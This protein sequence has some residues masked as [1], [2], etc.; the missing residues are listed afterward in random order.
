MKTKGISFW[1][2]HLEQFVLGLAV[3]TFLALVAMQFIGNPNAVQVA[4]KE[5]GPGDIDRMLEDEATQ[6][7]AL[8]APGGPDDPP[9]PITLLSPKFE[10]LRTASVNPA[11]TLFAPQVRLHPMPGDFAPST[12]KPF[13]VASIPAPYDLAAGQYIDSLIE[14]DVAG[15]EGLMKRFP[16]PPFDVMWTTV[17]ARFN[18]AE[19]LRQYRTPGASGEI[20]LPPT[21]HNDHVDVL[22]VKLERREYVDGNWTTPVVIDLL[23][24]QYSVREHISGAVTKTTGDAILAEL[25]DP[26]NRLRIIQ[27][28]FFET[29]NVVWQAPLPE[30]E[31]VAVAEGNAQAQAD[32]AQQEIIELNSALARKKAARDQKAKRITDLRC[33]PEEAAPPKA[34]PKAP[35]G[36]APPGLAAPGADDAPSVGGGRG[37][38]GPAAADNTDKA[39]CSSLRKAVKKLE[40]DIKRIEE[41]LAQL[42]PDAA[43]KVDDEVEAPQAQVPTD[44]IDIWAHDMTVEPGKTYSY[45]LYVEVFNPLFAHKLSL[46]EEQQPLAEQFVSKSMESEWTSPIQIEQWQQVFITEAAP[47][48]RAGALGVAA[49]GQATAE[50]YRYRDGQWWVDRFVVKP[51]DRVGSSRDSRSGRQDDAPTSGLDF[52]CDWFVLDVVED[53]DAD[54]SAQRRNWAASVILQSLASDDV[55]DVRWPRLDSASATR[56]RLREEI[57]LRELN[58]KVASSN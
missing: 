23:P 36:S 10:E 8:M 24:G 11:P 40:N 29:K 9:P 47:A 1:E 14:Q 30:D 2:Q 45:R 12:D 49:V 4:G 27:P 6:L 25:A 15:N 18:A 37:L 52:R 56:A 35:R 41:R 20:A 46:R 22:D 26:G 39:E 51:G 48:G 19:V 58:Q 50:V 55:I 5:V 33:P 38:G 34:P 28:E 7:A 31:A 32:P 21:W 13:V 17:A 44:V 54:E 42:L 3:L 16:Q 43:P 57:R 53:I